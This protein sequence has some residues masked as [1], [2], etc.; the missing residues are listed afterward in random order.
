MYLIRIP[1]FI[2]ILSVLLGEATIQ[3]REPP[4]TVMRFNSWNSRDANFVACCLLLKK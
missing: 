1:F 3:F 4:L 2:K